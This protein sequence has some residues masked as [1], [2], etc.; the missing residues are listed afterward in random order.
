MSS[1]VVNRFVALAPLAVQQLQPY[2]PGKPLEELQ[3]EYGVRE[4]IK[5]ASN[6]NPLGSSPLAMAAIGRQLRGLER[7]PDDSGFTLKSRLAA[8]H[9]VAA[10]QVVLGNGSSNV[11]D[12][13]VRAFAAPGSNVVFSQ[14]A[15]ILYPIIAKACGAE[16]I[17][18]RA[19][20]WGHDLDA[21]A[22][23]ITPNTRVVF[24]TNPNNPTGTWITGERLAG[25]L[26]AVPRD[27]IVV[28][29][30]AYFEYACYA[31]AGAQGYPDATQWLD[32]YDNLV[33][34]RT[35]SKAYGLAGLRVGYG[36]MHPHV[37]ALINRVRQ[38]FNV[39]TLALAA[40][41]AA[42]DDDEFL[43]RTQATN[44]AGLHQLY[45]GV[46]TLGCVSIASAANFVCLDV[47]RDARVVYESL[48]RH[49]VIVRP[50]GDMPT[51]LR[52]T[53]GTAAENGRFLAALGQVLRP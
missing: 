36:L 50:V 25:F 5:L 3:R 33:V 52:V 43:R 2:V 16:A 51:H 44:A 38:P 39:N 23:A 31:P 7:Y 22:K 29:D 32:R 6:E 27:V 26:E 8:K 9:G 1:S 13:A 47:G 20:A 34:T 40:A 46:R 30:E 49:G 28:V 41:E 14:H 45:D 12:L 4:A 17:E 24:V 53:V 19:K 35:F 18:V 21:M 48:L 15:F 37:A 42:L 11:L 10:D